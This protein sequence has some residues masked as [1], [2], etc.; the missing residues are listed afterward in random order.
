MQHASQRM[1]PSNTLVVAHWSL[2][3]QLF[4]YMTVHDL[5]LLMDAD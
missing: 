3:V 1:R 2:P 5:I 4:L